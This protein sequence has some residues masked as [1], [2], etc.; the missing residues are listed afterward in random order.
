M[1]DSIREYLEGELSNKNI[2]KAIGKSFDWSFECL[3]YDGRK[4]NI[5]SLTSHPE[6]L[7]IFRLWT[8]PADKVIDHIRIPGK[9]TKKA[10]VFSEFFAQEYPTALATIL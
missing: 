5:N 4:N 1:G 6:S 8:V 10:K 7:Y 3:L 2:A 9:I